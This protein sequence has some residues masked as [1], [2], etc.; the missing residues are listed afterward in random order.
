MN[1]LTAIVRSA[2]NDQTALDGAIF[3]L[4]ILNKLNRRVGSSFNYEKD[5]IVGMIL[6]QKT[7]QV[8]A[9]L[10]LQTLARNDDAGPSVCVCIRRSA[11]AVDF[12]KPLVLAYQCKKHG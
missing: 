2:R 10:M 6:T 5:L 8:I 7:S 1:F 12:P 4:Q 11:V 9:Q 3:L